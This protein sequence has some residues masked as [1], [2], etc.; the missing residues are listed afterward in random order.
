[1]GVLKVASI[2]F[3]YVLAAVLVFIVI[4]FRASAKPGELPNPVMAFVLLA[5]GARFLLKFFIGLRAGNRFL[6]HDCL[7]NLVRLIIILIGALF[8]K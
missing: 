1:M 2:L 5:M 3:E 4:Q 6:S 7:G 8:L